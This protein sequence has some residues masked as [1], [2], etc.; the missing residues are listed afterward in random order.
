MAALTS[1]ASLAV[2][3]RRIREIS[4]WQTARKEMVQGSRDSYANLQ[5]LDKKFRVKQEAVGHGAT[6]GGTMMKRRGGQPGDTAQRLRM[7]KVD[8]A[9]AQDLN[10][11]YSTQ[12]T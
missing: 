1:L 11:G 3:N 8:A 10:L 7:H 4:H 5:R 12:I 2:L 9:L 6:L